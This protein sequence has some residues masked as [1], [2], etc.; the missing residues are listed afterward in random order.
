MD[1]LVPLALRPDG[2]VPRALRPA[3]RTTGAHRALRRSEYE[4]FEV[5][6][7]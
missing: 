1:G 5:V 7:V 6:R 4:P 2:L 3:V